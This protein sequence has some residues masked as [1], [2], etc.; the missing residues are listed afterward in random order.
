[1]RSVV[2]ESPDRVL[3]GEIY[4]PLERLV[5]YYGHGLGGVH[6]PFNFSLL[7]SPWRARSIAKLIDEYE[8]ALPPGGW[9]TGFW[10]TMIGRESRAVSVTHRPCR[11]YAVADP[12]GDA[13]DLLR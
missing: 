8:A 12:S 1:M 3:I 2:D 7:N 5:T 11:R 10:A 4:L 6:L 13:D 9:L